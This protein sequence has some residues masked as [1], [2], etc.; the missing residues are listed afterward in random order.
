MKKRSLF[1]SV[2]EV[3]MSED[4][5]GGIVDVG[6]LLVRTRYRTLGQGSTAHGAY[7]RQC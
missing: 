5:G 3:E 4:E 2:L 6:P 7:K 1:I